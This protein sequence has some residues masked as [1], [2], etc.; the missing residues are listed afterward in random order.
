MSSDS[1]A[2]DAPAAAA[3]EE[4]APPPAPSREQQAVISAVV[5]GS[6]L[7]II[8]SVA[9]AGKTTC[10]LS[11]AAALPQCRV[12]QITYNSALKSEEIGRA[13]CRERV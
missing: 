5:R 7:T 9:G 13:S 1:D 10:L 8:D 2:P 4:R 3:A 11:L 6:P 12:L